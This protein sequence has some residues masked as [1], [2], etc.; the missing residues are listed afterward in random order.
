MKI[1]VLTK[2]AVSIDSLERAL[3]PWAPLTACASREALLAAA[4]STE[5]LVVQNKGFGY[6]TVDAEVLAA[7]PRLR[8]IQHHGV[9]HDATDVPAAQ[10]RGVPV[11]V[12]T[13]GNHTSVAEIAFHILLAVAKRVNA[14]RD[15]VARGVIG[16]V[17]C[18]ELAGKTLCIVGTGRIG[19]VV[20]RM[21]RGFSMRV[22]G[23]RRSATLDDDQRAAGI[24]AVYPVARLR[25]ALAAADCVVLA[26]PLDDTTLHLVG[27]A[28]LAAMKPGSLLVNVSRG[29]N[30]ERV[31]LER[32]L[33]DGRLAAYGTDVWWDEPADPADPLLA[34]PRV[35]LT[36]HIG[37]ETREAIDRMSSAVRANVDRLLRGEPLANAV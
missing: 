32:T 30:V 23:V 35:Y 27:E 13:G 4:P 29:R 16:Q 22:I 31:A 25:E 7:A 37:A 6:R 9:M 28:E 34:D 10:G 5:I 26:I 3:A 15:S 11:A 2:S 19:Q 18:T 21:A 14:M 12:T 8:L 17:L 24:E 1:T 36:P 33:A 20:A